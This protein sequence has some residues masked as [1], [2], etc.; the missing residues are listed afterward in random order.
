MPAPTPLPKY[1]ELLVSK[2]IDEL[3]PVR[4]ICIGAGVSGILTAIRFPREISNLELVVYD[5]NQ[6]VGGT[7]LENK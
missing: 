6:D 7:W 3:R 4:V 1:E 2:P 5:K